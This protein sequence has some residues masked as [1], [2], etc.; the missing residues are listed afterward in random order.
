MEL[1]FEQLIRQASAPAA[2]VSKIFTS[3]GGVIGRSERCDWRLE[4]ETRH[5]SNEHAQVTSHNG[6]FFLTD[7]S[8]N[9]TRVAASGAYLRKD[10]PW[11]VEDGSVYVMGELWIRATLKRKP[12]LTE[13]GAN[14]ETRSP[15]LIPDDAFLE[16]DP[17]KLLDQQE[18]SFGPMDELASLSEQPQP[19][20]RADYAPIHRERMLVPQLASRPADDFWLRFGAALG[21]DLAALPAEHRENLAIKAAALLKCN[22]DG[23]KQI[24]STLSIE[25][26]G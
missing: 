10:E 14:R 8:T 12:D 23:L 21:L 18:H 20:Q 24:S 19:A 4:D 25:R 5:L 9:G 17:L 6:V 7:I 15:V 22:V 11:L 16:L 1:V 3:D 26:Q 2:P 13:E